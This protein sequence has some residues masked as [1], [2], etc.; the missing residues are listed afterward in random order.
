MAVVLVGAAR[1]L[2][3]SS[4]LDKARGVAVEIQRSHLLNAVFTT[5]KTI[6][7]YTPVIFVTRSF[8]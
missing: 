5:A 8:F 6:L 1:L 3:K 4:G 2:L 7:Y